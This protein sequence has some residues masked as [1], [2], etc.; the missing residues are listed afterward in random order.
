MRLKKLGILCL[1]WGMML[2][3]AGTAFGQ[4]EAYLRIDGISGRFKIEARLTDWAQISEM[5]DP[6]AI[7]SGTTITDIR[8]KGTAEY[9]DFSITKYLDKSSHAIDMACTQGT[10]F[11]RITI[12]FYRPAERK[13]PFYKIEMTTVFVAGITPEKAVDARLEKVT[14]KCQRIVWKHGFPKK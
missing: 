1:A 10:H 4:I 5:P 12:E 7:S 3:T 6:Y 13:K 8:Q 11:P 14:F 9:Q 2:L